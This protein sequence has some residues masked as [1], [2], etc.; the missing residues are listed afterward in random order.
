M[1]NLYNQKSTL[2]PRIAINWQANSSSSFHIGYG[3]HSSMERIHNYFTRVQQSD[4]S[5]I[6]PNKNLDFLKA[7][8][9]IAGFDKRF[10]ENLISKVEVYYQRLYNLPVENNDTSIYC[11]INEGS[12]YRYVPLVNKGTGKNYGVEVTLERFY[13][14]H[15]YFLM[16]ASVFDSKYKALDGIERNTKFNSNF[17]CNFLCGK[18]F[19]KLGKKQ[20]KTL[21]INAKFFINGGQRYIPLLRDASGNL[22]VEPANNRFWDYNKAYNNKLDY[23]YHFDVSVSYK[24]NR[25]KSTHELFLDLPNLTNH[26][27][28]MSEYYDAG[29]PDK[30]GYISQMVFLPNMMY[31]VYF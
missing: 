18:E 10:S 3:K 23:L 31:R 4:G 2:E 7:D 14:N 20:N 8:H 22:A 15:Y 13:A 28:K 11:T 25:A 5:V 1:N 24:I 19:E 21:A 17:I 9:F 6:E 16:N 30:I 12:D 27:G 26:Q 29:K